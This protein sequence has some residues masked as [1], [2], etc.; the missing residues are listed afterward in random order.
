[1]YTFYSGQRHSLGGGAATGCSVHTNNIEIILS[2]TYIHLPAGTFRA[3]YFPTAHN[4]GVYGRTEAMGI[5]KEI[6]K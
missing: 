3:N 6:R 1:M 2:H 5:G 4:K